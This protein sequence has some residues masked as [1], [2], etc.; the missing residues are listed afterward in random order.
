MAI[1]RSVSPEMMV[2][3]VADRWRDWKDTRR[4][5]EQVWMECF[6]A[7]RGDSSGRKWFANAQSQGFSARVFPATADAVN[8]LVASINAQIFNDP[9]WLSLEP[10][11]Y[12]E[13]GPEYDD[14]TAER[15]RLAMGYWFDRGTSRRQIKSG[16]RNLV[17]FG[18]VVFTTQWLRQLTADYP[19]YAKQSA[20]YDAQNAREWQQFMQE[21]L[22]YQQFAQ[23]AMA[24]G[25]PPP[26]PPMGFQPPPPPTANPRVAYEGPQLII[27]DLFQFVTDPYPTSETPLRIRR[28]TVPLAWLLKKAEPDERTGYRVYE[29]MEEV[30]EVD[31]RSVDSASDAYTDER[32][33]VLGFQV[34][35]RKGVELHEAQGDM[36]LPLE[37]EPGGALLLSYIATVANQKTLIR[38]EP[39]Y[40][41]SGK[42]PTQMARLIEVPGSVYGQGMIED[43]LD[44]GDAITKRANQIIDAVDVAIYPEYKVVPDPDMDPFAKSGPGKRHSMSDPNNMTLLE[45]NLQGIQVGMADLQHLLRWF[46]QITRAANPYI[47][48]G[49]ES[50]ATEVNRNE[51]LKSVTFNDVAA[52][53]EEEFIAPV[54]NSYMEHIAEL[55]EGASWALIDQKN[56]GKKW[57]PIS[58]ELLRKGW[59]VRSVATKRAVDQ[60]ARI[61]D[62]MMMIELLTGNQVLM[63]MGFVDLQELC[64]MAWREVGL[65]GEDKVFPGQNNPM[66]AAITQML[67][68]KGA[69]PGAPTQEAPGLPGQDAAAG[70]ADLAQLLATF[71]QGGNG[72]VPPGPGGAGPPMETGDDG[73]DIEDSEPL[74]RQGRMA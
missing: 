16:I 63:Q 52:I 72:Q 43:S 57:F 22:A 69:T 21:F 32:A 38:L 36:I 62:L 14:V 4:T 58:P 70:G 15:L 33:S 30:Q 61:Q 66:V 41:W 24:A 3:Y 44:L 50:T 45:K 17:I 37:N 19:A 9:Q 42:V 20:E 67:A 73:E 49:S 29:N 34:P 59:I 26:P 55:T 8:T 47:E 51:T 64:K 10:E 35:E 68:M 7:Y 6:Q 56:A 54:M 48:T 71:G 5:K 65:P 53:V 25:Q 31:L 13:G 40:L 27:D 74:R 23:Q 2:R 18:N 46:Q 11:A 28:T 1:D 60:R 39:T 12:Q